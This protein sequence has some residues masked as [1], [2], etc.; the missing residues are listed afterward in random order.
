MSHLSVS[1]LLFYYTSDTDFGLPGKLAWVIVAETSGPADI[2]LGE[3][4]VLMGRFA[5]GYLARREIGQTVCWPAE[6]N[7]KGKTAK[8]AIKNR[9]RDLVLI[10]DNADKFGKSA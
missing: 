8:S 1:D 9:S 4:C 3:F 5:S 6:Q 2:L 10:E 7:R